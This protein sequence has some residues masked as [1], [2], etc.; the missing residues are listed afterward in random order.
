ME[1]I[2]LHGFASDRPITKKEDDLLGRSDF[3]M[4]LANAM[5]SWHGNDS[6]VIALHG[7]WGSGKSSIKNMAL[8]QLAELKEKKPDVIEFSPWEWASQEKITASF[9]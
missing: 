7:E 9:F 6:L 8:S 3:S 2:D 1:Q 4:D 5:A